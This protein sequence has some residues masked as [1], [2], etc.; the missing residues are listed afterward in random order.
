MNQ[1]LYIKK[2]K[3]ALRKFKFQLFLSLLFIVLFSIYGI[4]FFINVRKKENISKELLNSFNIQ[5]LYSNN[6]EDYIVVEMNKNE[7][8]F[9][10]GV[11]E[12]P[13][14]NIRYP[15]LSDINDDFLKI[16]ACRFYGPYPNQ[17]R[18][19]VCSCS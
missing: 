1:I 10:I 8:Y 18:K 15:I 5:K 2:P 19:H 4:Y 16:S 12:I 11:I 17:I 9:V 13:K 3:Q 7:K 14:I 6:K